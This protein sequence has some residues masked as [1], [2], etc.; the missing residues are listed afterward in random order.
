MTGIARIGLFA[1]LP[2]MLLV[3]QASAAPT[4]KCQE[5]K[6]KAQGKLELCLKKNSAKVLGGKADASTD[7][8]TKFQAALGKAENIAVAAGTTACRYVDNGDG[9][10]SD[11]NTGLQ[12]EKKDNM[13]GT[14]NYADPH[15]AENLYTWS[16]G[17]NAGDGTLY[18]DFLAKLNN[19]A[20]ADGGAST[21]ITGCFAGHC[22]WRLPSIV[23]LQG[24]V[25]A[26]QGVC[27]GGS[28][29]CIDPAFGPTRPV[30]YWSSTS[31]ADPRIAW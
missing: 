9:T 4:Q 25:D 8:Q 24:I 15:D 3:E 5:A 28:G 13:D 26:M 23:E 10:V 14:N 27:G 7:C 17:D 16:T 22:D 30:L 2:L 19:G 29:A 21:P 1:S 18:T 12:W 20:S 6:L 31:L 11:L